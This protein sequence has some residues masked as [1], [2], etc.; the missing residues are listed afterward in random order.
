VFARANILE[1]AETSATETSNQCHAFKARVN[2]G[3]RRVCVQPACSLG[4]SIGYVVPERGS[5]LDILLAVAALIRDL[6]GRKIDI[7]AD[8]A[9]SP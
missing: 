3:G 5:I 9:C 7:V 2:L 8:N 1:V 6:A 4:C